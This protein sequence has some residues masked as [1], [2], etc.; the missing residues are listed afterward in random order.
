MRIVRSS[1][2]PAARP[3]TEYV[4]ADLS[5]PGSGLGRLYHRVRQAVIGHPLQTSQAIHERL[6]KVKALAVLSSDALSSTAYATEEILLILVLA[7]SVAYRNLL[8]IGLGIAALLAIVVFSYRQTIHAYPQGGGSYIVTKDNL[9]TLPSLVAAAALMTDYTLTVAV[10][11][12][13]GVAAI[14]SAAPSLQSYAVEIAVVAILVVTLVNLRGIRESG[15]IFAIPT[16]LFIV[17]MVVL[18]LLGFTSWLGIGL[19][20]HPVHNP[21]PAAAQG[22][23]LFLILRAFA[24]GCTALTGVEAISDGVPAFQEPQA[25]NAARTLLWMGGILGTVFLGVT[26]LTFHFHLVPSPNETVVSQLARSVVGRSP[27]YYYI[28]AATA[29]ILLL[30]ANTSFSDFPRLAFFLARDKF[31]P[32]QFMYRGDRLAYSTGI[33]VLGLISGT[34]VVIFHASVTALIPLYAVGVFVAFTLSQ[35]SMTYRWVTKEPRGHRRTTGMMINGLGALT[36]GVVALVIIATKFLTGA[37]I[38]MII[39]PAAVWQLLKIHRHYER[40]SDQL[41][42][43]STGV[44][45]LPLPTAGQSAVIVPI[46]TLNRASMVAIEYARQISADVSV[47]HVADE[48]EDAEGLRRRWEQ[49]GI[50]LP[51]TII[52][53][54]YRE[55]VG[56]LVRYIEQQQELKAGQL[57]TVVLPEFVPAHLY[58][59]PLHNQTAWRLRTALWTHSGI[60]VTSVPYRLHD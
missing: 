55:L 54:P 40:V 52:E 9:G 41:A 25:D 43:P 39:V 17:G 3:T 45:R 30:A 60:A 29:G 20:A 15:S 7:G 47:V 42:M 10:S 58:E 4:V 48:R 37:W 18:L 12:S 24:S 56:P 51:L 16:Y 36:T 5:R 31:L 2:L 32:H 8:P 22:L 33:V 1:E 53:S 44:E 46:D 38:V 13:A 21:I 50:Q 23:T 34:L 19:H 59:I 28:Q 35:A 11:I 27:F 57:V 14:T 6:T 49:S 26:V